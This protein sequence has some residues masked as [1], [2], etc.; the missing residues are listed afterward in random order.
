M[1]GGDFCLEVV[2]VTYL[3]FKP[4]FSDEHNDLTKVEHVKCQNTFKILSTAEDVYSLILTEHLTLSNAFAGIR[5]TGC[6]TKRGLTEVL[7]AILS[8][9]KQRCNFRKTPWK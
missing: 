9:S 5:Q 1:G 4:I 2:L 7:I 8:G 6:Y 3:L